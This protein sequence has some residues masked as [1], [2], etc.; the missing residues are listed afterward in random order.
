MVVAAG[1]KSPQADHALAQLCQTYWVPLYTYLRKKGHQP[2]EAEDLVQSFFARL[3]EKAALAAADPHRGRFR[4]FL[5]ASL[6]HFV[7]NRRD[8]DQAHKR[9]GRVKKFNLDFGAAED[10]YHREP[11]TE[12]TPEKIFDRRWALDLLAVVLKQLQ[13]TY[14]ESGKGE[15][16]ERLRPYLTGN[17]DNAAYADVAKDLGMTADSLKMAA[18]R[19]RKR[20]REILRQTIADTVASP[21]DVDDEIR[22][23]FSALSN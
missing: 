10:A 8:H 23:L 9:G 5:V 15:L 17:P 20:Y 3:I 1:H 22:H 11:W 12:L 14:V 21:E 4:S 16:F 18:S 2:S 6:R 13:H 7:A 19:L